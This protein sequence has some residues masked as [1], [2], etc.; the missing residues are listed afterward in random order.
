MLSS[1]DRR[2]FTLARQNLGALESRPRRRPYRTLG[3]LTLVAV[4][5][6][7]AFLSPYGARASTLGTV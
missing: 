1:E 4:I 2:S 7:I 5:A 3:K 6:A